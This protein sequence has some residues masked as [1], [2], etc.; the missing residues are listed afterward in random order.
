MSKHI[1]LFAFVLVSI[2]GI[3]SAS[4][5][6]QGS[7]S[8]QKIAL[9]DFEILLL[10]T[11]IAL[12][13]GEQGLFLV[14]MYQLAQKTV[15]DQFKSR[16]EAL[17][18]QQGRLEPIPQFESGFSSVADARD[19]VVLL[20][21]STGL[22]QASSAIVEVFNQAFE[23]RRLHFLDTDLYQDMSELVRLVKLFNPDLV[24]GPLERQ[25][26]EAFNQYNLQVPTISFSSM[27][28][29]RPYLLSP[30]SHAVV[31]YQTLIPMLEKLDFNRIIWLTD[32]SD[33]SKTLMGEIKAWYLQQGVST[34]ALDQF[35][36]E[37][38]VDKSLGSVLGASQSDVRSSW[39]QRTLGRNLEV[40]TYV[41]RDKT[42][43]VAVLSQ[44]QALQVKPLLNFYGR[45]IDFLWLPSD[46]PDIKV[47][48]NSQ[49]SWQQTYA[50]L[51]A[52]FTQQ[53]TSGLKNNAEAL[54]I[55]LFHALAN[56]VATLVKRAESSL[57]FQV[58]TDVGHLVV[59]QSGRYHFL[60]SLFFLDQ[61]RL[62]Q[63]MLDEIVQDPKGL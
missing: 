59:D 40:E 42:L 30:S 31:F 2:W 29:T 24:I 22:A 7:N 36:L 11:E 34:E 23:G 54:E 9:L 55:G 48:V 63:T 43:L 50:L 12:R 20:P 18:H 3:N 58:P 57:P 32:G 16:Y 38:G 4:F 53:L 51:P 37:A 27:E 19:I 13:N 35:Q 56:L 15:P 28:I 49:T 26:A 25:K 47:F 60:P 1:V 8:Q 44:Q 41:R 17:I 45:D 6:D 46:L 52:H 61:G 62:R 10:R 33:F 39:L 21:M 14:N 5:A